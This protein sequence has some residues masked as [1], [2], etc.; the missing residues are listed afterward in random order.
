MPFCRVMRPTKSRNGRAGSMPHRVST[1]VPVTARYSSRSMPLWI[2][3]TRAGS[4]SNRRS[5]SALVSRDTATTASASSMAV[6]S[7]QADR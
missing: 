2:T 5:T 6:R 4:T 7:I 3:C 1:S